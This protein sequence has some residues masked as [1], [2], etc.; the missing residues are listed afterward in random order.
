MRRCRPWVGTLVEIEAQDQATIEAGFAAIERVHRLMSAHDPDS[1]LTR[2]NRG[3]AVALSPDSL[4]VLDRAL[5]WFRCSGGL[6][7][8]AVAGRNALATNALPRHD[9]QQ[10]PDAQATFAALVI[11]DGFAWLD[12]PA[13]LDLGGI[14][15]GHAVDAAV[16]AMR[17][18]GATSGLINAGGDLFA[19]GPPQPVDVVDPVSRTPCFRIMI[20]NRA[21]ATSAGL[22]GDHGLEFAHLPKGPWI[23]VSVEA[24]RAIDADA[25]TKIAF[26]GHPQLAELLGLAGARAAAISRT[27]TVVELGL[28]AA[29]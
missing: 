19:F 13:C 9:G 6:F 4:T 3:Q 28:K 5:Y 26:A 25:L 24:A 14:A 15:K 2:L 23:S 27:G 17:M 8:P 12:R 11:E 22:A 1:E 29:A 18:A 10:L 16:A 21:L 7:D 20:E